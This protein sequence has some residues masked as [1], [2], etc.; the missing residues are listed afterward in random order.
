MEIKG[1]SRARTGNWVWGASYGGWDSSPW[2]DDVQAK[3][4]R[5]EITL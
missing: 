2:E 4:W 5:C 3:M 1:K